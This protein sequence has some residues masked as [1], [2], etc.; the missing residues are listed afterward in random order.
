MGRLGKLA[1]TSNFLL[2]FIILFH[3]LPRGVMQKQQSFFFPLWGKHMITGDPHALVWECC[4]LQLPGLPAYTGVSVWQPGEERKSD[5]MDTPAVQRIL[6]DRGRWGFTV[7]IHFLPCHAIG[8]LGLCCPFSESIFR[9]IHKWHHPP[10]ATFFFSPRIPVHPG[11]PS[12]SMSILYDWAN[13]RIK[14]TVVTFLVS[15]SWNLGSLN[16]YFI[17]ISEFW[18]ETWWSYM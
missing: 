9:Q 14:L 5:L 1:T 12:M 13:D 11:A 10:Q 2:L 8:I 3:S 18:H 15:V 7:S 17:M 4:F 16:C 6:N